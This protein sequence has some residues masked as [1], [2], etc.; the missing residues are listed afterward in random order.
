L[1]KSVC[2]KDYI[3]LIGLSFYLVGVFVLDA[4]AP[5]KEAIYY[6]GFYNSIFYIGILGF[7]KDTNSFGS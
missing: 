1:F 7:Y 6:L 5:T 3:T 2:F 4:K